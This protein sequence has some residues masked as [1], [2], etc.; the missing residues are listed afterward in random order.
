M[1]AE[2]G[3]V[4]RDH[5]L[6]TNPELTAQREREEHAEEERQRKRKEL[7]RKKQQ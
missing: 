1:A 5:D 4:R 7:T 3:N 2:A 6:R